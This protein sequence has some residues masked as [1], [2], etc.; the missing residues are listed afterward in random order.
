MDEPKDLLEALRSVRFRYSSEED[1]QL[2][3]DKLLR[4]RRIQFE[5]EVRLD[6][7]SRIDLLVDGGVGIEVKIGGSTSELG[8]QVLRYLQHPRINQVV[9]VTTRAT[10]RDLPEELEGK[11]IWVVYLFTSAF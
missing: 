9:V 6:A 2:G 7:H 8:H 5:R 4:E 10:H 11:K 1:L 3:I